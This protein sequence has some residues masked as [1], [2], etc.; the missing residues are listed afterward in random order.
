[1]S[2]S[3]FLVLML[4]MVTCACGGSTAPEQTETAREGREAAGQVGATA[5]EVPA[6][7]DVPGAEEPRPE[8]P[9]EV[10]VALIEAFQ[11]GDRA[12]VESLWARDGGTWTDAAGFHARAAYYQKAEFDLDP[13]SIIVTDGQPPQ[14]VVRARQDGQEYH[15]CFLVS[16]IGGTLR[17]GGVETRPAGMP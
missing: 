2:G 16:E 15:W 14:V 5:S 12:R 10:V 8:T 17:A 6:D 7:S 11:A 3:R 4:L 9:K 13:D 1:M